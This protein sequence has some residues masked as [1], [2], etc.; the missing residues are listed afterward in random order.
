MIKYKPLERIIEGLETAIENQDVILWNKLHE[1]YTGCYERL[2][3]TL[4]EYHIYGP[5]VETMKIK[6]VGK[7]CELKGRWERK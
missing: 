1:K 3:Q 6:Y 4:E 2:C 7:L 5:S